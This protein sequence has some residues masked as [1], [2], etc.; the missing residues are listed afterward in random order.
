MQ[1]NGTLRKIIPIC[2][3]LLALGI[4]AFQSIENSSKKEKQKQQIEQQE[5][6]KSTDSNP[7]LSVIE[8]EN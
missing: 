2:S 5:L 7:I 6:S 8:N 4:V 3:M 1:I